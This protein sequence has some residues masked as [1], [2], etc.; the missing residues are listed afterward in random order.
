MT[1]FCLVPNFFAFTVGYRSI[2]SDFEKTKSESLVQFNTSHDN[3]ILR[4]EPELP[5]QILSESLTGHIES[6]SH[7]ED[8]IPIEK[9]KLLYLFCK[10]FIKLNLWIHTHCSPTILMGLKAIASP[11]NIAVNTFI[12][13]S[14][15]YGTIL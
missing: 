9:K 15:L 7:K 5:S 1:A 4:S 3:V 13:F 12:L 11:P 6:S 8:S 10:P 14:L 2:Q